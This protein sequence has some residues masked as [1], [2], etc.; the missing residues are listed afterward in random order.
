MDIII[1]MIALGAIL[2][3]IGAGGSGFIIAILTL[4]FN[5]PIHIALGTSLTAMAFTSLSGAFSHYREGNM[6]VKAGIVVGIFGGVG[7]FIGSKIAILIPSA[8]IQYFTAGML[9]LSSLLLIIRLFLLKEKTQL[10]MDKRMSTLFVLK[11]AILGI[12]VGMLSG[13]FG[14]GSAPFIQ[15]GLL[16]VLGITLAQSVGTT[17]LIIIP[18]A[19]GGGIGFISEGYLDIVLLVQVLMGTMLG[20]Y[21]GAKFTNLVPKVILKTAMILTPA[22]SALLLIL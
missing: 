11:A 13:T 3:F 8:Y 16:T 4:I 14:I 10:E 17:L 15:L 6:S 7:S 9:F 1:T 22:V 20:A 21:I 12:I 5:V 18:I 2:G 19:I